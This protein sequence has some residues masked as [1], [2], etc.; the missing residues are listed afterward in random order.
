M[1]EEIFKSLFIQDVI[2]GTPAVLLY[3]GQLQVPIISNTFKEKTLSCSTHEIQFTDNTAEIIQ[4]SGISEP[5][6]SQNRNWKI[7]R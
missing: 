2:T 1:E 5:E 3:T 7:I 4:S 6:N